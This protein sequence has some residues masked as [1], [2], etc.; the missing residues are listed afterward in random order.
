MAFCTVV[1]DAISRV[2]QLVGSCVLWHGFVQR[3]GMGGGHG[4]SSPEPSHTIAFAAGPAAAVVLG[5]LWG[6]GGG[7]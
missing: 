5:L 3:E 7:R 4:E 2:P 6:A 1:C